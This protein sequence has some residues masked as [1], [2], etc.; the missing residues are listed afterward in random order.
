VIGVGG[1]Q[2]G[3]LLRGFGAEPVVASLSLLLDRRLAA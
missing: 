2:Q 3:D 1:K